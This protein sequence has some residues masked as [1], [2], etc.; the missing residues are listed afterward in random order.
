MTANL[1]MVFVRRD[2]DERC[3]NSGVCP[4]D[5]TLLLLLGSGGPLISFVT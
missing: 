3:E 2:A 1:V 5:V 4:G